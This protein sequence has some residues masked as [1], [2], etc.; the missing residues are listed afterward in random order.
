MYRIKFRK[1]RVI[2]GFT[3]TALVSCPNPIQKKMGLGTRLTAQNS[4]SGYTAK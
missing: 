3:Q 1:D 4:L 2:K